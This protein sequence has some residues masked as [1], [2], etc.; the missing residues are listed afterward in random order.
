LYVYSS[1]SCG[2]NIYKLAIVTVTGTIP[3]GLNIIYITVSRCQISVDSPLCIILNS[4]TQKRPLSAFH[5]RMKRSFC[6]I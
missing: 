1:I 3:K 2:K 5:K 6:T 4:Q